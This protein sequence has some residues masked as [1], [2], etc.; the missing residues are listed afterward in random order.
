MDGLLLVDKPSGPT[1]FDVVRIVRRISGT[2][3]VGHA[4]TLDPLASGL[5][6]VCLGTHTRLVPYLM[7]VSKR[8]QTTIAL[9]RGT[10]TDDADGEIIARAEVAPL[11]RDDVAAAAA[12]FVGEIAQR[13][14]PYSALKVDGRAAYARARRGEDVALAP[15]KVLIHEIG[16]IGV[17]G[18]EIRLDVRCGAGTYIRALA[19]D[20][21]AA[22]GT[23]GHVTALRRIEA[24][25]FD[26]AEAVPAG[27][28]DA[29]AER[30]EI[31]RSLHVGA[32]ALRRMPKIAL[33]KEDA[34]AVACGRSIPRAAE[35]A[36]ATH[37]ALLS[38]D[39]ALL[40]VARV[41]GDLL[42]PE[43]GFPSPSS[44]ALLPGGEGGT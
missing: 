21:A 35:L 29:L 30:G 36:D 41:E 23:V 32:A 13:P 31:E 26:V 18:E 39:G 33:K 37:V 25:G 17:D 1:S 40:A 28:L 20:L 9:G 44:S 7:T 16:V 38:P 15:R 27:E 22:L 8:Y 14:P 34:V 4:G 43:R 19:R 24:S 10:D 3:R 5:L 42:R 11:T 12:A 2:R 6:A